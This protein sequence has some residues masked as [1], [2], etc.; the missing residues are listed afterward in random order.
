MN[1]TGSMSAAGASAAYVLLFF[2]VH[3]AEQQNSHAL[4]F[5]GLSQCG[6]ST[7]VCDGPRRY[8]RERSQTAVTCP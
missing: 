2:L 4:W 3:W 8:R 5:V 7:P 6:Q 1:E